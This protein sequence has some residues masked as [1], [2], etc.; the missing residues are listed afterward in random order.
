MKITLLGTGT[1]FG[2]PV[3]G[4][5]CE[6]CRSNNPKDKRRRVA[7]LIETETTRILLDAGPD[8]R[9]Q[10]LPL[11]FKPLDAILITHHHY[12]HVGGLDD[13][14]PFTYLKTLPIYTTPDTCEVLRRQ[15]PYCFPEHHYP[16]APTFELIPT[17]P[18]ETLQIGDVTIQTIGVMHG[19]LPILGFRIGSFAFITDMKSISSAEEERLKGIKT[20]VVNALRFTKPHNTHQ[21]V[22][23]AIAFSRR[24]GAAETYFIHVT[25][26]IGLHS[27]ANKKL[28][29]HFHFAYDGQVIKL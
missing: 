4:C 27:E 7:A 6:V 29:P 22:D 19:D 10:L 13:L 14:R 24:I 17:L 16:G 2:V 8:I 11:D 9:E 1:S 28:P 26:D 20:L 5:G 3:I 12:D 23:D 18:G 15:M 25:H 21:L